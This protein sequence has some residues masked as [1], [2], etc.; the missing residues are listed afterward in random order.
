MAGS[1]RL[2]SVP[3]HGTVVAAV[4]WPSP[5]QTTAGAGVGAGPAAARPAG[6]RRRDRAPHLR[7]RAPRRGRRRTRAR[8]A[9]SAG[10]DQGGGGVPRVREHLPGRADPAHAPGPVGHPGCG[11]GRGPPRPGDPHRGAR[12]CREHRRQAPRRAPVAQHGVPAGHRRAQPAE[13]PGDLVR[14]VRGPGGGA[15]QRRP[16]RE[17]GP[18][19]PARGDRPGARGAGGGPDARRRQTTRRRGRPRRSRCPDEQ[20]RDHVPC[21]SRPRPTSS[22]PARSAGTSRPR[23]GST[24]STRCGSRPP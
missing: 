13:G 15:A 23:W 19:R 17:V 6:R 4:L 8:A 1:L 12:R 7:R 10:L 24:A 22:P 18:R 2:H 16:H 9:G 20:R 14:R 21:A 5:D 11:R 3:G